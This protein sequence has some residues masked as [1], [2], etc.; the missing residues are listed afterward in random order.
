[1]HTVFHKPA[2]LSTRGKLG[3][4]LF[5]TYKQ[6]SLSLA[7]N[8]QTQHGSSVHP[9]CF[10]LFQLA[11]FSQQEWWWP[12]VRVLYITDTKMKDAQSKQ[13]KPQY[14]HAQTLLLNFKTFLY[15]T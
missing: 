12:Y 2:L 9:K 14:H 1:M 15:P 11:T 4:R 7:Y 3:Q 10:Y 13:T 6:V 5:T 8:E